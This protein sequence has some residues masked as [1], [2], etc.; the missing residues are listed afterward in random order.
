MNNS[1]VRSFPLII[2][3]KN[4][5]IQKNYS[6]QTV[7]QEIE[8]LRL[9]MA[10]SWNIHS[11][12]SPWV[13]TFAC[14]NSSMLPTIFNFFKQ[15]KIHVWKFHL[16]ESSF[17]LKKDLFLQERARSKHRVNNKNNKITRHKTFDNINVRFSIR[18]TSQ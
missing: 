10:H 4:Q 7:I 15:S 16:F 3:E 18:W 6:T 17:G 14:Q 13:G 12:K 8:R 1:L 5:T 11:L 9:S 2:E